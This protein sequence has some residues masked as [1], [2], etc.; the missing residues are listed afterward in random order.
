MKKFI[1]AV[2]ALF[3][4]TTAQAHEWT[5]TYPN[6]E[7]S[8]LDGIVATNMTL[9]NKR[10]DIEYYEISVYDE[11]WNPVP[12][13]SIMKLINVPYLGQK[14]VDIY[15]REKDFNR[16][17]YICTTSKRI[18]EDTQSSGIDSRICSKV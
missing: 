18:L 7:P 17:E 5:P 12:F 8:F 13:A 2:V 4:A 6:F 15:I 16:I 3:L 10:K 1:T 9:F 14:S 11:D